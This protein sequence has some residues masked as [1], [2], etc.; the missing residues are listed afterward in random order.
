M[1]D[2][3]FPQKD[4]FFANTLNKTLEIMIDNIV[5]IFDEEVVYDNDIKLS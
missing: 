5:E 4:N 2:G 3:F 1:V